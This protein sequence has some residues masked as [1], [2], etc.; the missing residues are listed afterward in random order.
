MQVTVGICGV[1][2]FLSHKG[3]GSVRGAAWRVANIVMGGMVMVAVD[4]IPGI[5]CAHRIQYI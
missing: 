5:R 4:R 3:S 2:D 1:A